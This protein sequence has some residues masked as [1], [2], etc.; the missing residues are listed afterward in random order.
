MF[1]AGWSTFAH[2]MSYIFWK[3]LYLQL[4]L[5][6]KKHFLSI[7]RGVRFLLTQWDAYVSSILQCVIHKTVFLPKTWEEEKGRPNKFKKI[8]LKLPTHGS[9]YWSCVRMPRKRRMASRSKDAS[10][11]SITYLFKLSEVMITNIN[12]FYYHL[13]QRLNEIGLHR[14]GELTDFYPG[15]ELSSNAWLWPNSSDK[16]VCTPT[17]PE[18]RGVNLCTRT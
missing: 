16:N 13:E 1:L 5:A 12:D 14:P 7:L 3:L 2:S 9:E 17:L 11:K 10:R 4:I 8:P 15:L 6:F 18:R